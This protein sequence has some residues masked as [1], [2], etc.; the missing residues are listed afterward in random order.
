MSEASDYLETLFKES[1]KAELD[2]SEKLDSQ[3]NLPTIIV[4]VF[5]GASA[6]YFEHRPEFQWSPAIVVFYLVMMLYLASVVRTIYC[7]VRSYGG[8][9]YALIPSPGRVEA[10]SQQLRA[11][12]ADY[13]GGNV[14]AIEGDVKK[15]IQEEMI[16]FY[17]VAA[18]ANRTNNLT[19][20]TWLFYTTVWIVI[21]LVLLLVSRLVFYY[22]DKPKPQKVRIISTKDEPSEIDVKGVTPPPV[23]KVEVSGALSPHQVQIT[24]PP[25]VQDVKIIGQPA[26]QKVEVVEPQKKDAK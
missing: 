4:T 8:Y 12:Y 7:M 1:Y 16:G 10:R 23:Q 2:R 6:F 24:N 15:S 19:R 9:A 13:Y 18:T 22:N 21:S 25:R 26:V 14:A 11:F 17:Q 20:T 5:L 3:I